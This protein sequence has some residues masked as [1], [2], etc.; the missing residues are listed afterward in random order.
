MRISSSLCLLDRGYSILQ[1]TDMLM[2]AGFSA[3]DFT[4][5]A[6]LSHVRESDIFTG[7]YKR[8][9][10][11]LRD[12]AEARGVIYNQAHAPFPSERFIDI[13]PR[14]I[15]FAALLGARSIVVH[16]I[17]NME[18]TEN[19]EALFE[20]NMRFYSS[21]IPYARDFG[22]RI[23]IENMWQRHRVTDRICDSTCADPA[24]LCRYYDTLNAP[25]LFT[26]CV[27]IGHSALCGR[28][29]ETVIRAVGG[30]RL[31]ALHV[32]DCD[33]I[34]D[35]HAIPYLGKINFDAVARALAEVDYSG[36]ITLEVKSPAM[37]LDDSFLPETLIYMRK[38]AQH[39]ASL[40]EKYKINNKT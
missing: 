1:S 38:T 21:L 39:L 40:T 36:D 35:M 7:D 4:L 19:K 27:D 3:L 25:D 20:S 17:H 9:A 18:Y 11:E 14:S 28:E 12:R 26:V 37:G 32:H 30:K 5:D 33:Y 2:D 8:L 24:E 29:P 10:R 22:I 31:G 15:E 16:P 13:L 23:A 6:K 34:E